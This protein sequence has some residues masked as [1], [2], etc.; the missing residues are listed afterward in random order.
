MI[1]WI[2]LL[3]S[4]SFRDMN[5]YHCSKQDD[6]ERWKPTVVHDLGRVAALAAYFRESLTPG[7]ESAHQYDY[8]GSANKNQ[9]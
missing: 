5:V 6:W 8:P 2:T 4:P 1:T 7:K 3:P 9:S